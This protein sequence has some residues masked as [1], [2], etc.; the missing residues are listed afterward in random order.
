MPYSPNLKLEMTYI[1]VV[2]MCYTLDM[3][4]YY[5]HIKTI[6]GTREHDIIQRMQISSTS[7]TN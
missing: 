1:I 4:T 2:D 5:I 6:A 7:L 3:I